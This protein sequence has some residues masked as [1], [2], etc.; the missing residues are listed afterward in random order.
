MSW[1][2]E[3]GKKNEKGCKM[4]R[5]NQKSAIL[6]IKVIRHI[7]ETKLVSEKSCGVVMSM[8]L[9]KRSYAEKSN[10]VFH[11]LKSSLSTHCA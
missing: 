4:E 10:Y 5:N 2:D 6:S 1:V 8:L 9:N 3:E 7:R 11:F